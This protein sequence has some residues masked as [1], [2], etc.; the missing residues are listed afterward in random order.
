MLRGKLNDLVT[1]VKAD[2]TVVK[3]DIKAMVQPKMIFMDDETLPIEPGDHL[4]HKLPSGLVADYLVD[5]PGFYP[6]NF[7][8]T[9]AHF[10]TKVQRSGSGNQRASTIIQNI[11]NNYTNHVTGD[12]AR[13]NINSVD[14]SSNYASKVEVSPIFGQLKELLNSSDIPDAEG[15]NIRLSIEKMEAAQTKQGLMEGYQSFMGHAANHITVFSP[16][17]PALAGLLSG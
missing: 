10:Q 2:G 5:D 14:N 4:L 17:L 9:P 1:L 8:R 3:E 13:V 16:L 15:Q 12:N 6:K 11:T 7:T